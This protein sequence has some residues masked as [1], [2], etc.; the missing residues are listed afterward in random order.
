M[1]LSHVGSQKASKAGGTPRKLP[2]SAKLSWQDGRAHIRN[3]SVCLWT[4][5]NFQLW[6]HKWAE[7]SGVGYGCGCSRCHLFLAGK[8]PC[9]HDR[10]QNCP[11][12]FCQWFPNS[13]VSSKAPFLTCTANTR[14]KIRH[15]LELLFGPVSSTLQT[16]GNLQVEN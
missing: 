1:N 10:T 2:V 16:Q 3:T 12:Y 6:I 4:E 5:W 7:I 13:L 9:C 14:T 11:F 8:K 15:P